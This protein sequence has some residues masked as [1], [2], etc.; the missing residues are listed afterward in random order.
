MNIKIDNTIP[1]FYINLDD[2]ADRNDNIIK[3]TKKYDFKNVTRI[4]AVNTRTIEKV[5]EYIDSIDKNAYDLLVNNN[6][7]G[8]RKNHYELTNGSIGCYLSHKKIYEEIV[9]NKIPYALIL[10]DDCTIE[11]SPEY[12]W[13]KIS[14]FKI[15]NDTD[16][17][18]S[19]E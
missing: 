6:K 3:L 17:F 15:P 10:E 9:K 11:S 12:F 14:N 5:N 19:I 7:N 13:N 2:N 16:I 18:L 4:S 1:L 8:T